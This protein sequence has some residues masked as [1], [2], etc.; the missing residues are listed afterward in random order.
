MSCCIALPFSFFF[1]V[2]IHLSA[3][4]IDGGRPASHCL[5]D[6]SG[7]WLATRWKRPIDGRQAKGHK[8]QL[9]SRLTCDWGAQ[10]VATTLCLTRL[11]MPRILFCA[12]RAQGMLK[13]HKHDQVLS[14]VIQAEL[15]VMSTDW[16]TRRL[17][18]CGD[19][20]ILWCVNRNFKVP[21]S[22]NFMILLFNQDPSGAVLQNLLLHKL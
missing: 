2:T 15:L 4:L 10:M 20:L 7:G 6:T 11:A 3:F 21:Y 16:T 1:F 17:S 22:T 8:G 12:N 9:D 19:E 18:V 14:E 13:S 5:P